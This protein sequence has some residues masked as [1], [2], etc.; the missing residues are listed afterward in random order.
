MTKSCNRILKQE[1]KCSKCGKLLKVG[2]EVYYYKIRHYR[3]IYC[4]EC[5]KKNLELYAIG[6][7]SMATKEKIDKCAEIVKSYGA[8]T[9]SDLSKLM[10]MKLGIADVRKIVKSYPQIDFLKFKGSGHGQRGKARSRIVRGYCTVLYTDRNNV[11]R[12]MQQKYNIQK[13]SQIFPKVKKYMSYQVVTDAEY[14]ISDRRIVA[15]VGKV[16]SNGKCVMGVRGSCENIFKRVVELDVIQYLVNWCS[17]NIYHGSLIEIYTS[18]P[19]AITRK[20][21]HDFISSSYGVR[22]SILAVLKHFSKYAVYNLE[23]YPQY[24]E[25]R[26]EVIDESMLS[27]EEALHPMRAGIKF[28]NPALEKVEWNG[29]VCGYIRGTT[30]VSPRKK[31]H[32][33]YKY[34]GWGIQLS[35]LEYLKNKGVFD[36]EIVYRSDEVIRIYR[37]TVGKFLTY[38]IKAMLSDESGEQ[39]FLPEEMFYIDEITQSGQSEESEHDEFS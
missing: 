11:Y 18:D 15:Y 33:C 2:E 34:E 19:D 30:Y 29:R 10:G 14:N 21:V 13:V 39:I 22:N 26:N 16:Y 28:D 20:D 25:I 36:I 17:E 32:Y 27:K 12:L 5:R 3:Y 4:L 23:E 38:G 7:R 6:Y 9:L 24:Q 35:I 8:I 37:S 1:E 31:K